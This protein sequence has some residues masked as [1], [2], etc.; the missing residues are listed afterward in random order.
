MMVGFSP[1]QA[2]QESK[3]EA[4]ESFVSSLRSHTPTQSPNGY[5]DNPYSVWDGIA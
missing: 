3:A 1:E 4:T 5:S 2:I